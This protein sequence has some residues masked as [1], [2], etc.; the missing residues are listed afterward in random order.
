MLDSHCHLSHERFTGDLAE[1]LV[2]AA[3]AGVEGCVTIG[4]GTTDARR[5][6]DLAR[7]HPGQVWCTA[8]L[9]PWTCHRAGERF[10]EELA[11]LGELLEEGGFVAVGE[12]GLDYHYDLDPR[13]LQARRLEQQLELAARLALPVVIHVREAHEDMAAVLASHPRC[14]GVIHSFSAGVTEAERYLALG[15]SLAFNGMLTHRRNGRLAAAARAAPPDRLLVE[16]D[17]PYL[18]PAPVRGM[19]CEP[20][21]VAHT[22]AR[23]AEVRGAD[24]R[25]VAMLTAGNARRLFGL[26]ATQ[27]DP[28]PPS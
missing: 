20:A 7:A 12:I 11:A 5:C 22:V 28:V 17:S 23:L 15:W 19:R 10:D 13:P 26:P 2:R 6:R 24:T 27:S 16:T 21:F 8:G 18:A 25:E 1:V 9:D 3:H 14:R 4:T